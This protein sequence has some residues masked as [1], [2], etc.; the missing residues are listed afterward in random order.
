LTEIQTTFARDKAIQNFSSADHIV[1][2]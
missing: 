2:E 1:W